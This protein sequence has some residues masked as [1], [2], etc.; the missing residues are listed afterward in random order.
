[1]TSI[2]KI[3]AFV[4]GM[5][6]SIRVLAAFYRVMDLW[7]IIGKAYPKI[8]RGILGWGALTAAIGL[9]LN[10]HYRSPF[11]WGFVVSLA[12]HIAF[13]WLNKLLAM[14]TLKSAKSE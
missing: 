9:T 11:L 8:L 5:Y 10:G 12:V 7:Y 3:A 13:I 1:M 4:L 6:L 2:F 14:R